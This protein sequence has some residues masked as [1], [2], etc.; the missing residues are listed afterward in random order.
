MLIGLEKIYPLLVLI[1]PYLKS[2]EELI[3]G[4]L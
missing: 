1:I 3:E 4:F 2:I